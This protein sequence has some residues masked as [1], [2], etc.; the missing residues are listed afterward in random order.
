MCVWV[1]VCV[2]AQCHISCLQKPTSKYVLG[3]LKWGLQASKVEGD[4]TEIKKQW[5]ISYNLVPETKGHCIFN[6][7]LDVHL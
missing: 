3:G 7:N 6:G 5:M 4:S 2:C 1:C